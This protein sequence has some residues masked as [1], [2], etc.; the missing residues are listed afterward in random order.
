MRNPPS[1]CISRRFSPLIFKIAGLQDQMPQST[2]NQTC[3][4]RLHEKSAINY[5]LYLKFSQKSTHPIWNNTLGPIQKK[6]ST[7]R[8][9]NTMGIELMN[10]HT[11]VLTMHTYINNELTNSGTK[12]A[13]QPKAGRRQ[14]GSVRESW[15]DTFAPTLQKRADLREFH[16]LMGY[17]SKIQIRQQ[18]HRETYE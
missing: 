2:H 13:K 8:K 6:Q 11:E 4:P 17:R 3:K 1:S 10:L 12:V 9:A 14:L 15:V 18:S 5:F 7:I 16:T